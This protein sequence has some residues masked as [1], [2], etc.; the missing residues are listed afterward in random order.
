[1]E[2]V[3]VGS[4]ADRSRHSRAEFAR[5][6]FN[7]RLLAA[8]LSAVSRVLFGDRVVVPV[9]VHAS[10]PATLRHIDGKEGQ[11]DSMEGFADWG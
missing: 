5:T 8:T 2:L 1:M 9:C 3:V 7:R 4:T 6:S 10:L 11:E